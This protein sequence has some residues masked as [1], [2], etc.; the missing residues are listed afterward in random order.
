[1]VEPLFL[2][3]LP[4]TAMLGVVGLLWWRRQ[5]VTRASPI[6]EVLA[7]ALAYALGLVALHRAAAP[8]GVGDTPL[9]LAATAGGLAFLEGSL[10]P[11]A[12][13]WV[14][15]TALVLL[16]VFVVLKGALGASAVLSFGGLM[17][18]VGYASLLLLL[19]AAAVAVLPERTGARPLLLALATGAGISALSTTTGAGP[20]LL[21]GAAVGL[22]AVVARLA[23]PPHGRAR[24]A[25]AYAL[26]GALWVGALVGV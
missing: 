24:D 9:L 23:A 10:K 22:V 26:A 16:S 17:R 6:D 12:A 19:W 14:L 5:R 13:R 20:A 15:R 3:A 7:V 8:L 4:V 1:M 2:V 11:Q 21:A 25:G 18:V